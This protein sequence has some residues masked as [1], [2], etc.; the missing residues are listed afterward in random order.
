MTLQEPKLLTKNTLTGEAILLL[1]SL[2]NRRQIRDS[3]LVLENKERPESQ[4]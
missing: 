2:H 3:S 1:K 4:G